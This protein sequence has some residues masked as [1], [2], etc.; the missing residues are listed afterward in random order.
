MVFISYQDPN[1][2]DTKTK[3]TSVISN[4][5]EKVETIPD[6]TNIDICNVHWIIF[7]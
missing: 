6:A 2:V 4:V 7:R 1:N 5:Y 3:Y